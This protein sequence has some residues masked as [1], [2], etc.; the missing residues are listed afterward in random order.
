MSTVWL[1]L[2]KAKDFFQLG[3]DLKVFHEGGKSAAIDMSDAFA[4][5]FEALSN[6]RGFSI[7]AINGYAMGGGLEC[8][9][10]L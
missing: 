7:A 8:A 2:A 1:L 9:L 4:K 3:A 5:A 6:F 10:G